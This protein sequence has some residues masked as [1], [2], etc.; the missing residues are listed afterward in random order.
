[1]D[2][3]DLWQPA[4]TSVGPP[5]TGLVSFSA[6]ATPA[7]E[8][9]W[10]LDLDPR[11]ADDSLAALEG[12]LRQSEDRLLHVPERLDELILQ[13]QARVR[14]EA[15]GEVSFAVGDPEGSLDGLRAAFERLYRPLTGAARVETSLQN[16]LAGRTTV[17]WGGKTQTVWATPEPKAG[18]LHQRNVSLA[19]AARMTQLRLVSVVSQGAVR[20]SVLVAGSGGLGAAAALPMAWKYVR[21]ILAVLEE[22][23]D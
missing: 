5:D 20:I 22:R 21:E 4:P 19:V 2:V 12:Q 1:M 10:Q 17:G 16:R 23:P 13:E 3:F 11:Q 6:T 8:A 14:A 9:V 7:P 18:A 15:A